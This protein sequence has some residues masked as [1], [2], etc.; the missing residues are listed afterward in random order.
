MIIDRDFLRENRAKM[1]ICRWNYEHYLYDGKYYDCERGK[2]D[3]WIV[4]ER[5]PNFEVPIHPPRKKRKRKNR[6]L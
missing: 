4:E 6:K 5:I 1:L 2:G 3:I